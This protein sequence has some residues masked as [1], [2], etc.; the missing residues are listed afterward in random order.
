MI[1][2]FS[3]EQHL[4]AVGLMLKLSDTVERAECSTPDHY[5]WPRR[6]LRFRLEFGKLRSEFGPVSVE[7]RG[8]GAGTGVVFG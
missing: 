4:P 2:V 3:Q 7:V 1:F 6:E 5:F 8:F